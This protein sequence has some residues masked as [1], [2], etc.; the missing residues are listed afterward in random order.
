[1]KSASQV[2]G[3]YMELSVIDFNVDKNA[4]IIQKQCSIL[5]LYDLF[6]WFTAIR[7]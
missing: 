3:T 6:P 4:I 2:E 5:F 1:M 7:T